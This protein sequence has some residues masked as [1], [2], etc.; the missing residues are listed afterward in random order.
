MK[1]FYTVVSSEEV[2]QSSPTLSLGGFKSSSPVPNGSYNSLF[3][4]ISSYSVQR[5]LTTY[6]GLILQNTSG[7]DVNNIKVWIPNVESNF[8]KFRLSVVELDGNQMEEIPSP[9]SK[10]L[11]AEFYDTSEEDKFE[12]PKTLPPKAMLGLWIERSFD[13]KSEELQLR[14]NCDYLYEKVDQSKET[15]EK[16]SIKISF[17]Y[18]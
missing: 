17:D 7:R 13:S 18:A 6:V 16:N 4:D 1:L 14:N 15:C 12:V 3:P 10:P 11:Y 9:N 8:C 5:D 2:P